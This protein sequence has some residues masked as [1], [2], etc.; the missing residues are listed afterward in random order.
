MTKI[1]DGSV[2]KFREFAVRAIAK[3]AAAMSRHTGLSMAFC[4]K[5]ALHRT[6]RRLNER[7]VLP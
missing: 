3:Q 5:M 2:D 6:K 1:G 4:L 7:N